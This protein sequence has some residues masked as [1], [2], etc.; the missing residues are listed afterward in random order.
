MSTPWRLPDVADVGFDAPF[1]W[2]AGGWADLWR[3]PGPCLAYGFG[4]SALLAAAAWGLYASSLA[5]WAVIAALGLVLVAPI[6]AMG[7]YEAGRRIEAGEPVRLGRIVLVRTALRPD[8]FLLGVALFLIFSIWLQ[9]AQIV[10]GLSTYQLHDTLPEFLAFALGTGEGRRMLVAGGLAGGV[11]A[12]AAYTLVVV[13]APMLLD[14][15]YDVFM[16]SVTSVRTV[17]RNP[18]P[19][20]LWAFVVAALVLGS[21]ATGFV[22]MIVVLPWL[23]LASRRAFRAL[24]VPHEAAAATG[25]A[26]EGAEVRP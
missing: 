1:R 3:T 17:L 11:I 9:A 24:V 14:P 5:F 16:A 19:M 2:L 8:V 18:G 26:G 12:F 10:Y 13:S 23:G 7:P 15:R 22:A 21:V 25:P 4:V 6:L 20:M